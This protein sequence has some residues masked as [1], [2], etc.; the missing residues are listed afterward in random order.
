MS[1]GGTLPVVGII[2]RV[3]V[4]I[5]VRVRVRVRVRIRVRVR[6]R[7]GFLPCSANLQACSRHFISSVSEPSRS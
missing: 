5:R 3:R 1:G 7:L 6:V 4:R 2:D